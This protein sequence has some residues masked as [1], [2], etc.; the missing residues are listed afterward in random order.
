M[1]KERSFFIVLVAAVL[2]ISMGVNLQ[3]RM[4]GSNNNKTQ[5]TTCAKKSNKRGCGCS[6]KQAQNTKKTAVA[7]KAAANTI[8]T[9][10]TPS[11]KQLK[12]ESRAERTQRLWQTEEDNPYEGNEQRSKRLMRER[13]LR[14]SFYNPLFMSK[15]HVLT[16]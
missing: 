10:A 12:A 6:K 14:M 7:Q 11:K 5:K 16:I 9:V 3:G 1:K 8:Q 4:S 15:Q 13:R 2:Y